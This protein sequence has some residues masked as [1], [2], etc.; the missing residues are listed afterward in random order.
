MN[1]STPNP[2]PG[3]TR[4][5]FLRRGLQAGAALAVT[6]GMGAWLWNR[7]PPGDFN[8]PTAAALLPAA[9]IAPET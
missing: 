4:R 2:E 7:H 9:S 1:P 5:E 3:P 6:G 8:R